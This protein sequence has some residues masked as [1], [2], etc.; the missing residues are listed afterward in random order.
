MKQKALI[1][2]GGWDGHQ[3]ELVS[4]RFKRMLEKEGFEVT[5]SD[6]LECLADKEALKDFPENGMIVKVE[7]KRGMIV[8]RNILTKEVTV[9][10]EDKNRR[11]VS[12]K[13]LKPI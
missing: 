9:E 11:K 4:Q 2:Y 3:P 10:L 8:D 6:T 5:L 12:I 1:F 7:G 13:D